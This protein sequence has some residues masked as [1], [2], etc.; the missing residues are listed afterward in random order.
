MQAV[1]DGAAGVTT[2]WPVIAGL[3]S[4]PLTDSAVHAFTAALDQL[5]GVDQASP[6]G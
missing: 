6:T 4:H 3:M 2:T 5:A 1:R